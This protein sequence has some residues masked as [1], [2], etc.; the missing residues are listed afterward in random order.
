MKL[1]GNTILITGGNGG[2]GLAL[3]KAFTKAENTVIICGRNEASLQFAKSGNDNIITKQ[4]DLTQQAERDELVQWILQNYPSFNV[5]INNAGIFEETDLLSDSFDLDKINKQLVIDLQVPIELCLRFLPHLRKQ[6]HAAI[7]NITSGLVYAPEAG[8]PFY[9]VAKAGVHAFTQ[10]ARYQLRDTK[11]KVFEVLPPL[12][13]TGGVSKQ[14]DIEKLG[15]AMDADETADEILKGLSHDTE[16]IRIGDIKWLYA[17][18][19]IAPEFTNKKVNEKAEK[20]RQSD[21]H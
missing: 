6:P 5:I 7:V 18:S 10:T 2:I 20:A 8:A 13:D 1:S 19:R 14:L 15:G 12:V 9:G 11:L 17:A 4:C 3:T 16:E 21:N